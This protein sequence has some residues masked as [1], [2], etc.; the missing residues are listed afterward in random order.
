ML[1]TS[2]QGGND[3]TIWA[4]IPVNQQGLASETGFKVFLHEIVFPGVDPV[5]SMAIFLL[6]VGVIPQASHADSFF[7]NL[8]VNS[9]QCSLNIFSQARECDQGPLTGTRTL[10]SVLIG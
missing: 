6:V 3:G 7:Y 10:S 2:V 5:R 4:K 8:V 9:V 1:K